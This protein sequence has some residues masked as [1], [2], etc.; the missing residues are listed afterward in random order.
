MLNL[1]QAVVY[2]NCNAQLEEL[3]KKSI[4]IGINKAKLENQETDI[5]SDDIARQEEEFKQERMAFVKTLAESSIPAAYV[6]LSFAES[7]AIYKYRSELNAAKSLAFVVSVLLRDDKQPFTQED[8]ELS[9]QARFDA[10][11]SAAQQEA[12]DFFSDTIPYYEICL[13]ENF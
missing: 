3:V 7:D 13:P 10:D 5:S 9:Y 4:Q 12:S 6:S 8:E 2:R 1:Q 11:L